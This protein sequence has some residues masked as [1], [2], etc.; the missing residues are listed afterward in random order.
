MGGVRVEPDVDAAETLGVEQS[1]LR[2]GGWGSR[3]AE[4]GSSCGFA[5]GMMTAQGHR[6]SFASKWFSLARAGEP[7]LIRTCR[8][9]PRVVAPRTGPRVMRST[10][11]EEVAA[12][13]SS[14]W[15]INLVVLGAVLEADL[16]RRK[17]TR[18]RLLRPIII[19]AFVVLVYVR[20]VGAGADSLLL[21]LALLRAGVALRFAVGSI[22]RLI[23]AADGT[24]YSR[25]G[26]GA[27][28]LRVRH[29]PFASTGHLALHPPDLGC[30]AHGG[31]D[32]HGR[33]HAVGASKPV[34]PRVGGLGP[35]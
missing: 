17:I 28:G 10:S 3:R 26:R 20:G 34:R 32:L 25:A 1:I 5:K 33:R 4:T 9:R 29:L 11:N 14:V 30:R 27:I 13:P 2:R 35:N 7:V 21:E 23:R 24:S 16:G 22:F 8:L 6:G 19:L 31:A 18:R 12:M 15:I